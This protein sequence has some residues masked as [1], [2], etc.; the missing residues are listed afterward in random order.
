MTK[1]AFL[2]GSHPLMS[3]LEILNILDVEKIS[4]SKPY[5]LGEILL[6]EMKIS[7]AK[8][9]KLQNTLGGT[10]KIIEIV[11]EFRGTIFQINKILTAERLLK[12][13]F[14]QTK[15]KINFGFS[16][17]SPKSL[18]YAEINWL[19]NFAYQTKRRL[20]D[21]Y[22]VRYVD[23]KN[24]DLSSV[25][26]ANNKLVETG[27]EIVIIKQEQNFLV[28]RTATVQDFRSYVQRDMG[29]P[30]PNPKSGMLPPKLAQMIV[31]LSRSSGQKT[32][33]DP[34]CG[35]GIIL[36]EAL[37]LNLDILGSDIDEAAVKSTLANLEW[38]IKTYN[39]AAKKLGGE[40]IKK[41][42]ISGR[43]READAT[44]SRWAKANT[45]DTFI[46]TEPYLG[47]PQR[48]VPLMHNAKKIAHEL[49]ELYLG[50][51]NNLH[52][53]FSKIKRIGIVFPVIK[54]NEGLLYLNILDKIGDIG[55]IRHDF[56]P[57][58]Q[59]K[60]EAYVS[61][62]GGLLYSRPDQFVLREIF[63]FERR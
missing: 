7:D 48:R 8:L 55:Y 6:L 31:N 29:K 22:S 28:G 32:V 36:Q 30:S 17:Y 53:N 33:F 56:L 41:T 20:K 47:P 52:N 37:L 21:K 2:L 45:T 3:F 44:R 27:A 57:S 59:A 58:E 23:E 16:V 11:D 42:S 9:K 5:R 54:T 10:I 60:K 19:R 35:S 49:E 26:V 13:Y 61:H 39:A 4:Y 50:F 14:A 34:F 63:V 43:I 51:F 15:S 18:V 62:R 40:K 25:M 46:A 38:L 1:Y 24:F 12:K